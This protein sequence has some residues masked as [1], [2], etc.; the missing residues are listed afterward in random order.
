MSREGGYFYAERYRGLAEIE[1]LPTELAAEVE[2]AIA[3]RRAQDDFPRASPDEFS[4]E[5]FLANDPAAR[6]AYLSG[7]ERF[8]FYRHAGD[9]TFW[10]SLRGQTPYLERLAETFPLLDAGLFEQLWLERGRG[11]AR[12]M[13]SPGEARGRWRA[14]EGVTL[15]LPTV[16]PRRAG[17]AGPYGAAFVTPRFGVGG[18]EKVI[19]E[20][21][22]AIERLTGLASLVIVADSVAAPEELPADAICLPNL[23]LWGEPFLRAPLEARMGALRDVVLRSGAPRLFCVNSALGTALLETGALRD[24]SIA[25]AAAVFLAGVGPGGSARGYLRNADWLLDA[26]AMLFTDNEAMARILARQCSWDGAVVLDMPATVTDEPPPDG[27]SVLWAGR[28][29]AQK[30]PDLLVEVARIRP[31]LT[32]EAWGSPLV[33]GEAAMEGILAQPNITYR[34]AFGSFSSL[35]LGPIGAM[36]YTSAYDGTPNILLE[37]MGA[38]VPCICSAVGGIPDLM[39]EGR[40]VLV[41]AEAPAE[42]YATALE[43]LMREP[44]AR[45]QMAQTARK[46]VRGRHSEGGFQAGVDRLLTAMRARLEA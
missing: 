15:D 3:A 21:A 13:P 8:P 12:A 33:S 17:P 2:A 7:A 28:I 5:L 44:G 39:G 24:A 18:S 1:R 9:D 36:L 46:Y 26:G 38:G 19:R 25:T 6:D 35:D 42:A 40:G 16:S 14:V 27:A 22:R 10:R 11:L 43:N 23:T 37:A 30:R 34:G 4:L 32:F 45:R 41:P 31:D 29:D 20:M